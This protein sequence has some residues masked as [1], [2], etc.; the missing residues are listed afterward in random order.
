M[1]H[2]STGLPIHLSLNGYIYIYIYIC[3]CIH[4]CIYYILKIDVCYIYIY[5][6]MKKR[7]KDLG[8]RR[9]GCFF[10]W[11]A[12]FA[13]LLNLLFERLAKQAL[14]QKQ[15]KQCYTLTNPQVAT[16]QGERS[17]FFFQGFLAKICYKSI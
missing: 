3:I 17:R 4:S 13:G 6:H 16:S 11:L 5:I 7:V 8:V 9:I 1:I 15:N 12:K 14:L 2:L 10:G